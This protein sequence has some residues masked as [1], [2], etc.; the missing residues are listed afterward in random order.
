MIN[1][2]LRGKRG[3]QV[4]E[5][6][7]N[8]YKTKE[9]LKE[10]TLV[11]YRVELNGQLENVSDEAN[12]DVLNADM[13]EM[14]FDVVRYNKPSLKGIYEGMENNLAFNI[15][16]FILTEEGFL[17]ID[18]FFKNS[19]FPETVQ[20]NILTVD[21]IEL[22]KEIGYITEDSNGALICSKVTFS[23]IHEIYEYFEF[24][25]E[26]QKAILQKYI[27]NQY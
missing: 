2:I 14:G 19:C 13:V 11:S 15:E 8:I 26:T 10:V 4:I 1:L 6:F 17:V 5:V 25:E 27:L 18:F 22:L 3:K 23:D 9:W 24:S 7:E 12:I 21:F 20:L 16:S